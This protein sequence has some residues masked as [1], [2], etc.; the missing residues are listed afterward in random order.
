MDLSLCGLRDAEVI[1]NISSGGSVGS[2]R[3]S[4]LWVSDEGLVARGR[5]VI[6]GF[7]G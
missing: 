1:G 4:Q 3:G 5:C 2:G 7:L 6:K